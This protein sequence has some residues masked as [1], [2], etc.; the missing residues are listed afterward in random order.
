MGKQRE[1]MAEQINRSNEVQKEQPD[2]KRKL[3]W[4]MGFAGLM[5]IALL[6]TL[7][8][9]DRLNVLDTPEPAE[10]RFTEAV[11]VTRK[12]VTQPVTPADA[13]P[14]PLKDVQKA[15]EPELS[16]APVE[17][18]I[19]PAEPPPRP[20]VF[21]RPVLPR[22]APSSRP[23]QSAPPASVK[24]QSAPSRAF[25]EPA[26]F[27]RSPAPITPPPPVPPPPRMLSGYS[28]QAGVFS[29]PHLAEELH[30]KLT[31]NGIPSTLET[32]VQLGPFKSRAEAEAV[33]AKLKALDVDAVLL[34]PAKAA[35]PR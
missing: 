31:R 29:D 5:I 35:A 2:L 9:F 18:A 27:V 8:V 28:L 20:E 23:V 30:A 24:T 32:R 22:P 21:S 4:R 7:A 6:V 3:V 25:V 33:H 11:P 17:Q 14:D 16:A 34:K 1:N 10:P 19:A 26:P 15:A 13:V 12:D